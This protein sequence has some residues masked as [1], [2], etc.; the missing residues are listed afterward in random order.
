MNLELLLLASLV[1]V[2]LAL[3]RLR[4]GTFLFSAIQ[5]LVIK[6]LLNIRNFGQPIT[7]MMVPAA[8]FAPERVATA[9]WVLAI[10][11]V[12]L[13]VS[14]SLPGRGTR[15]LGPLQP[16]RPW[17]LLLAA[18]QPLIMTLSSQTIFTTAYAANEQAVFENVLGGGLQVLSFGLLIYF[19]FRR[20]KSGKC[21]SRTGLL[22]VLGLLLG[23]DYLKGGTGLA[24]GIAL[25]AAAAF[26]A[27]ESTRPKQLRFFL[28]ALGVL[29][30]LAMAVRGVRS[31]F[32]EEGLEAFPTL[33]ERLATDERETV[34][35]G[36]GLEQIGNGSQYAAHLL[37]C[38]FLFDSGVSR[39]WRSIYAP[40]E[41]TIKPSI[42]V[43]VLG[44]ERSR[45]AAWELS[46]YFVHGGG[47]FLW[48]ELY[49]NG[50]MVCVF[51]VG[52][53]VIAFTYLCD[54]RF[55]SS[56][57]WMILFL[58]FMPGLLQGIGYGYAQVSRGAINGLILLAAMRLGLNR[59]G[60][61]SDIQGSG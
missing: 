21:S 45:E 39:E 61:A 44:W 12:L 48:G 33:A 14:V 2:F 47:I 18:L 57:V 37:E 25:T 55:S 60:L 50:G 27:T 38:I 58:Q 15:D 49:W 30:L 6:S 46:D 42:A 32:H 19:L 34:A 52:L 22:I 36:E 7:Q 5:L 3:A 8:I 13:A 26:S 43:K 29:L 24:T 54:T 10:P 28:T 16:V 20:V 1:I 51:L 9:S 56:F 53:L 41:Y 4:L 31:T 23:T 35:R 59:T 17:L 11:T 40:L